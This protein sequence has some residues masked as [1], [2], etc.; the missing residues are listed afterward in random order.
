VLSLAP[1]SFVDLA[2]SHSKDVELVL[3]A[4]L[5]HAWVTPFHS[6]LNGPSWYLSTLLAFW[7]FVPLW[8]KVADCVAS[9]GKIFPASACLVL[10]WLCTLA[11]PIGFLKEHMTEQQVRN[12]IEYSP[13]SNWQPFCSGIFL[14]C[15][16][17]QDVVP[18]TSRQVL[19]SVSIALVILFTALLLLPSPGADIVGFQHLLLDKG[20]WL[21]P[22][23]ALLLLGGMGSA[24]LEQNCFHDVLHG[25]V[26]YSIMH[27]S[28]RLCW[29]VF[30]LHQPVHM[31]CE[32]TIFQWFRYEESM[33]YWCA[34][35]YPVMLVLAG[36]AATRLIDQPWSECLFKIRI[37]YFRKQN[38]RKQGQYTSA[39]KGN[40]TD[41]ILLP[42]VK[43]ASSS[44]TIQVDSA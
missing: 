10:V 7:I 40:P 12:F 21:Q 28:A 43:S 19:A 14:A 39:P 18:Y 42:P 16:A 34:L 38:N 4:T 32:R 35:V 6:N 1:N 44:R 15:L 27:W 37:K 9:R 8:V 33:S 11:V 13:Y 2:L 17:M 23:F 3:S 20:F 31:L 25:K 30:I 41:N 5:M 26:L 29:P 24:C 22:F 36:V